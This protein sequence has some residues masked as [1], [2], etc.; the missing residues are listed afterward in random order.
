MSSMRGIRTLP[1]ALLLLTGL[2]HVGRIGLADAPAAV[3]VGFG[4]AYLVIGGMLLRDDVAAPCLGIAVPLIGAGVG[5][6]VLRNPPIPLTF[7]LGMVQIAV[8]VSCS[9]VARSARRSR[10]KP[11]AD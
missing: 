2:I 3:V 6:R 11:E 10:Q 7:L 1:V 5:P 8:A 9:L 4:L